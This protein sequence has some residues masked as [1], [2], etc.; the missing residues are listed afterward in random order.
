MNQS[1]NRGIPSL[2]M[3]ARD[4]HGEVCVWRIE[5][6]AAGISKEVSPVH[7][8]TPGGLEVGGSSGG[9][10]DLAASLLADFL[11]VSP[12]VVEAN[13]KRRSRENLPGS[14]LH[15]ILSAERVIRL[16]QALEGEL[17]VSVQLERNECY[18]LDVTKI[19]GFISA[20][21]HDEE[22]L[23]RASRP[24]TSAYP[25]PGPKE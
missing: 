3:I 2:Y 13:W 23:D 7:L 25:D 9:S 22:P 20:A 18:G 8:H 1:G 6:G 21:G 14:S 16:H 4:A 15:E 17:L 10:A 24:E 19:G 11:N 12:E 5:A